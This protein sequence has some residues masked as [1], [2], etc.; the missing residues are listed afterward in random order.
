MILWEVEMTSGNRAGWP[1]RIAMRG[2][3]LILGFAAVMALGSGVQVSAQGAAAP[4]AFDGDYTGTPTDPVGC[5]HSETMNLKMT[6]AAGRATIHSVAPNGAPWAT[7]SGT[8]D[9]SGTVSASGPIAESGNYVSKTL[10][11]SIKGNTF[12]GALDGTHCHWDISM[13]KQ[14]SPYAQ[15]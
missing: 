15:K 4:T 3:A 12:T 10:S 2:G 9:P 13:T 5:P 8:V 14:Q 6:I 7:F 1:C 11:G